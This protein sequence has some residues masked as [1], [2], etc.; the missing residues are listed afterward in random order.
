MLHGRELRKF[1]QKVGAI[2]DWI[3]RATAKWR[4]NNLDRRIEPLVGTWNIPQNPNDRPTIQIPQD[5]GSS[6]APRMRISQSSNRCWFNDSSCVRPSVRYLPSYTETLEAFLNEGS[7]GIAAY[8]RRLARLTGTIRI[9]LFLALR[10]F[11]TPES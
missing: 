5:S 3:V 11:D 2:V 1:V 8:S 4:K 6:G 10:M 7:V 9:D